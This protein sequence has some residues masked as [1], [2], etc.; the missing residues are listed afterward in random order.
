MNS[1]AEAHNHILSSYLLL[2]VTPLEAFRGTWGCEG[3]IRP[4]IG[5]VGGG[6]GAEN[7]LKPSGPKIHEKEALLLSYKQTA[8]YF[9]IGIDF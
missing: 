9:Y 8:F 7:S 5:E 2:A 1:F 6:G 3:W 4:P